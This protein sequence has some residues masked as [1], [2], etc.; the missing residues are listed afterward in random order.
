MDYP[1]FML[2]SNIISPDV[3]EILY[4]VK[5]QF[6]DNYKTQNLISYI[7]GDVDSCIIYSAHYNHLDFMGNKMY[8]GANDNASEVAMVLNLAKHFKSEK[9][10]PH[11]TEHP[12][13]PLGKTKMLFNFDIIRTGS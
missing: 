10:K 8:P 7:Y 2:K 12:L 13:V 6:I 3:K 4:E 1:I 5:S 9:G 11:Y